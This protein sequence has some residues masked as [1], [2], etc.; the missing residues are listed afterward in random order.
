MAGTM[1]ISD[2]LSAFCLVFSGLVAI[3]VLFLVNHMQTIEA[4]MATSR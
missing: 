4:M 2:L 1:A 3:V